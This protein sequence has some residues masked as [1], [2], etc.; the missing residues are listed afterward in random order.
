MSPSEALVIL[1]QEVASNSMVGKALV[2]FLKEAE[3]KGYRQSEQHVDINL[4][5][6]AVGAGR[7]IHALLKQLA[8]SDASAL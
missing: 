5:L 3:L 4:M 6:Q 8:P 2:S 7:N 1:K